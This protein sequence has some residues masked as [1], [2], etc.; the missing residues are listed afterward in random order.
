M[1]SVIVPYR[2]DHGHRDKSWAWVKARWETLLPEAEIIVAS[3]DGGSSPGEFNHPLAIN[4]AV[5]QSLGDVLLI[6]DADTAFDPHWVQRAHLLVEC[7]E[8]A[9]VMPTY[10]DK[11]TPAFSEWVLE[12]DTRLI[13]E[14]TIDDIE[15]E[16]KSVSWSG[17]VVVPREG[18]NFVEGYDE[19]FAWWGADD[20]AFGLTMDA[21]WGKH[22]RLK[23]AAY[24]LWHPQPT[25]DTRHPSARW[26]N[27]LVERYKAAA[28]D[29]DAIRE[30]RFGA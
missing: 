29:A 11:L 28:E 20:V 12:Q 27:M 1:L 19:R 21:L 15:W 9:W 23:G 22:T 13:I 24:H 17:L 3:D 10:Y 7:R 26:Q 4:R 18:F 5:K 30:V 8:C 14:P 6:A 25:T 2:P 16:G